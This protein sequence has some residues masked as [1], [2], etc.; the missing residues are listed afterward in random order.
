MSSKEIKEKNSNNN[1]EEKNPLI[2]SN[3]KE[4][5]SIITM[6]KGDYSV[7]VLIEEVKNLISK[8]ENIPQP[9]IKVKV[10]NQIQRTKN[11]PEKVSSYLIGEHMYY[12]FPNMTNEILDSSKIIIEVSDKNYSNREDYI[13]IYE[14]D[15]M[16]VYNNPKHSLHNYWIALANPES[17][18]F[19]KI[20]GYIRISASVL[21]ESDDRVEL[22]CTSKDNNSN[23]IALPPQ[24]KIEYYQIKIDI[25][26]ADGVPDMDSVF[27]VNKNK[28]ECDGY[29]K[30]LY[31]GNT[32]KT[33]VQEM[34]SNL[35]VWNETIYLPV[36]YPVV[37]NKIC[38]SLWDKDAGSSD[39][40]IGSFEIDIN[41]ILSKKYEEFRY[42]NIYGAPL[43][44]T[45]EA[46]DK[47]NEN[48]EIGSLWKGK[49]LLRAEAKKTEFPKTSCE[50]I[51]ENSSVLQKAGALHSNNY[52]NLEIKLESAMFLPYEEENYLIKFCIQ[53][54]TVVFGPVKSIN[55]F[56]KFN[57]TNYLSIST[58][59]PEVF[60]LG[61]LVVYLIKGSKD[62]EKNRICFQKLDIDL[63][64]KNNDYFVIKL[65]PDPVI[66]NVKMLSEAGLIKFK[67]KLGKPSNKRTIVPNNELNSISSINKDVKKSKEKE[68]DNED[69]DDD[70]PDALFSKKIQKKSA[71]SPIK[72]NI[73]AP[74]IINNTESSATTPKYSN[75]I[76][77]NL[78][79]SRNLI[80]GDDSGLSDPY[81]QIKIGK[82][83]KNSTVKYETIN[84]T[85]NEVIEFNNVDYDVNDTSTWPIVFFQVYDKDTI[86]SDDSLGFSYVWITDSRHKINDLS[87]IIPQWINLHLPLSNKKQGQLLVS[88]TLIDNYRS[89]LTNKIK[90]INIYPSTEMYSFEINILGLRSLQHKGILPIKKPFISFDLNSI[91]CASDPGNNVDLSTLTKEQKAIE[92][93]NR[94]DRKKATQLQPI[95][96][97]PKQ[98]GV[99]PTINTII[100][101]NAYLPKDRIFIPNMLCF[102]YDYILAGICNSLLGAF[103]IN[104]PKIEQITNNQLST[105][106][107]YAKKKL[108]QL[109][110]GNSIVNNALKAIEEEEKKAQEE[111]ALAIKKEEEMKIK[112]FGEKA[113]VNAIELAKEK[114]NKNNYQITANSD[115]PNIEDKELDVEEI[116]L[117][118]NNT[119]K[120]DLDTN[121][122]T[123]QR[124]SFFNKLKENKNSEGGLSNNS[125]LINNKLVSIKNNQSMPVINPKKD[126]V[127]L[128]QYSK[129]TVPSNKREVV[130]VNE[131][132]PNTG[133]VKKVLKKQ[134]ITY[135]LIEDEAK[136]PDPELY[137][138]IG[139][140]KVTVLKDNQTVEEAAK[141]KNDKYKR[142]FRRVYH[143]PL[144]DEKSGLGISSPFI[145]IPIQSGAYEDK[146]DSNL[147]F[148]AL[149]DKNNK[150]LKNYKLEAINN[151]NNK[152]FVA[153]TTI[154][155]CVSSQGEFK[156]SDC[157]EN[158]VGYFK[159]LIKI[160]K[161]NIIDNIQQN[162]STI[163]SHNPE[164]KYLSKYEELSK[165][166]LSQQEVIIRIYVL[167]LRQL[168]KKDVCSESDPYIKII[169]G[170]KVI[171]DSKSY[172]NDSKDASIRKCYE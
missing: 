56:C 94:K 96:T 77:V 27:G 111:I 107:R 139:Y 69:E 88:F 35:L 63:F 51:P 112:E 140:Q 53:K 3:K 144:E 93:Q 23:A 31:M 127:V 6:K 143:C 82:F 71:H 117:E 152:E 13:G 70:D 161:K 62:T 12:D 123:K 89:D 162:I 38:L 163:L 134:K 124:N 158:N 64:D 149:A 2:D 157:I 110:V 83:K 1:V 109:R 136:Y 100:K 44:T 138:S 68:E 154:E 165:R 126:F 99:N 129:F 150:I 159:G 8:E 120:K 28:Q 86:S 11:I 14:F 155:S 115:K 128:P 15:F 84:G 114:S 76:L 61:N 33:S 160:G 75:T 95:K 19:K 73:N 46:A 146:A 119:L 17:D 113:L 24:I 147:I 169:C 90:D 42:V 151:N 18:D 118:H 137:M 45:G 39:D 92:L 131:K 4:E 48:S 5:I 102:V 37:S 49:I 7:H 167:D 125:S 34:K 170:D 130:E 36:S 106:L 59:S 104:I 55:G 25:L 85:W 153:N 133:K 72:K 9:I 57:K 22:T 67:I 121:E 166:L 142:H 80:A 65:L 32:V 29:I 101:F 16:F 141:E 21:H 171:D 172:I 10:N 66:G 145:K 74:I 50:K 164:I 168:A 135:Y 26:K 41:N 103:E 47:M 79:Q 148:T 122:N 91:A 105:D 81:V 108:A 116:K 20:R 97:E 52:W 43:E 60:D 98:T 30:A 58:L 87:S 54:E 40:I 132:D 78:H 156:S